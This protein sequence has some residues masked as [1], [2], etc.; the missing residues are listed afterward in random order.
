MIFIFIKLCVCISGSENNNKAQ[1][2]SSFESASSMYSSIKTDNITEDLIL[3]S[4][5][6]PLEINDEFIV[7]NLTSPP[8]HLPDMK[9]KPSVERIEV[10]AEINQSVDYMRK[11][12]TE[13]IKM[14]E[15]L[16]AKT[17]SLKETTLI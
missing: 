1:E 11:N 6:P 13:N 12:K 17:V 5:S 14:K 4:F 15:V 2:G 9:S 16:S 8:L 3:P 10:K 7:P